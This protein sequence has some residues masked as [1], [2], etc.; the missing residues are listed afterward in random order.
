MLV[1]CYMY[2]QN[3]MNDIFLN[4]SNSQLNMNFVIEG[5]DHSIWTYLTNELSNEVIQDGFLCSR[6]TILAST[7][8]VKKFID[9]GV[10]PPISKQYSNEYTLQPDIQ[11]KEIMINWTTDTVEV[12]VNEM[13]FLSMNWRTKMS[14]SLGIS[15]P[16]PYGNPLN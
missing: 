9:S 8:E 10:A 11:E 4:Q 2:E 1:V 7:S 3:L 14:Y 15:T 13:K 5:D 12:F 6:G 16:G